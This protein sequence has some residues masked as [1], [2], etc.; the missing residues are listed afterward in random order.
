MGKNYEPVDIG[1]TRSLYPMSMIGQ[2]LDELEASRETIRTL[3]W[4]R[5]GRGRRL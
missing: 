2:A 4:G 1:I 5:W 3:G